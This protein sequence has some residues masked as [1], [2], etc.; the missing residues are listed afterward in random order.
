MTKFK[1]SKYIVFTKKIND[2]NERIAYSIRSSKPFLL[3]PNVYNALKTENYKQIPQEVS[4]ILYRNKILVNN[5]ENELITIINEN[6][7][8]ASTFTKHLYEVIQP[9]ANCQLDCSYCGQT[10]S[11]LSMSREIIEKTTQKIIGKFKKNKY[12]ELTIGWFGG[13]PLLAINEM[14]VITKII[15]KFCNSNSIKYSAKVVTNGV[16]LNK[17]CFKTLIN[18]LNVQYI[19][20]TLDGNKIYH[21][22]YRSTKEKQG[23]F[24]TI[25]SNLIEIVKIKE[26]HKLNCE[27]S[28]RCNVNKY[29]EE[30]VFPLLKILKRLNLHQYVQFYVKSIYS[31][32]QNN[33][34]E[35]SL[36]PILFAKKE[37]NWIKE[38]IKLSFPVVINIPKRKSIICIATSP[39][40]EMYDAGGNVFVCSE[41]SY[42]KI[43]ENSIYHIGNLKNSLDTAEN[44]IFT[45]WQ[46]EI[47]Y[48]KKIP[49]KT[50]KFLP[51]CGGA[52]PK[53]WK[54]GKV[55]CPSFKYNLGDKLL[56]KY[57]L[58][59]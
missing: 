2:R 40:S 58:S 52:C 59:H 43:Y 33:A 47:R 42:S 41:T 10:H 55:P 53:A 57:S 9:T 51:V 27:I 36:E 16:L 38:M 29:N 5:D 26:F 6:K 45:S 22:K 48:N 31:W 21:D 1:L 39:F 50:C 3:S 7:N 15:K 24:D 32:G 19:E 13:E 12:K 30:G 46:D 49:C 28:I 44:R 14:R 37:I 20:I 18:E 23:S 35:H 25:I 11:E 34:D 54:E 4:Q 8:I 17:D 56:L